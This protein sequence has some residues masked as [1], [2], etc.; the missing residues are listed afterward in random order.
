MTTRI[1]C[2]DLDGT[3]LHTSRLFAPVIK[4]VAELTGLSEKTVADSLGEV[5]KIT[6]TFAAWFD[7]L[8]IEEPLWADLE[9]EF[10]A[11]IAARAQSCIYPGLRAILLARK[12]V[13]RQVLITAGEPDYQRWKFELLGLDDIFAEEDRHYI[14]LDGSKTKIIEK[15]LALGPVIFIDDRI[16]WLNEVLGAHMPVTCIRPRWPETK[17]AAPE[18]GDG[19]LWQTATT[20]EEL[21]QL[22]ERGA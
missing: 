17:S 2:W 12:Q 10:R 6:F 16:N 9:A 3:I 8:V 13:A 22:L 19:V 1:D 14:P 7:D 5:S 21:Q 11:D 15:Y 20:I 18:E 4:R